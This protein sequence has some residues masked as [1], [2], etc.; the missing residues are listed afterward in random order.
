MKCCAALAP[1]SC[2]IVVR[3]SLPHFEQVVKVGLTG[4]N[5]SMIDSSQSSADLCK[6]TVEYL[7]GDKVC[8][9]LRLS[10]SVH[11]HMWAM[12]HVWQGLQV[13]NPK[14]MVAVAVMQAQQ[15]APEPASASSAAAPTAVPVKTEQ[16]ATPAADQQQPAPVAIKK[17]EPSS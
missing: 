5:T 7:R 10:V 15:K 11:P 17:E 16:T 13:G 3:L 8:V 14:V 2:P 4:A 12:S 9:R 1:L 6:A